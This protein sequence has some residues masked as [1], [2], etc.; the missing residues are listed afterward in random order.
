VSVGSNLRSSAR[1][2]LA[3]SGSK[4]NSGA[5]GHQKE[6]KM[7]KQQRRSNREIRK[8]KANKSTVAAPTSPFAL[9][10]PSVATSAPKRKR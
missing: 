2:M 5:Q 1:A 3:L 9:K 4:H 8:P 10:A 6:R 7:A